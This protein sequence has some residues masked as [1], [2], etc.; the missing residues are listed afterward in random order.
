[1]TLFDRYIAVDWSAANTPRLGKDSIW[2]GEWGEDHHPGST[3]LSPSHPRENGDPRLVGRPANGD[4]RF[5][6]SDP[7]PSYAEHSA[8]QA[9]HSHSGGRG[10]LAHSLNLPTRGAAMTHLLGRLRWALERGERVFVGCDFGFGYPTGTASALTGATDWQV[11][12]ALI[13]EL[14]VD[15]E[16]NANNRFAVAERLNARLGEALFWGHPHQHRYEQLT[17]RRPTHGYSRIAE[18]RAVESLSRSAQPMFKLSGVGSVGSQSL[19]GI[20]RL[21][22]LRTEPS[23]AGQ[24]A[25]WPFETGFAGPVERPIWLVEMYPSLFPLAPDAPAPKDRAQVEAAA[26]GFA[27]LDAR[28]QLPAFLSPPPGTSDATMEVVRRE[29]GW[30]AGAGRTSLLGLEIAA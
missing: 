29:E 12:W 5:R 19:T 13:A 18:R 23:L 26:A 30:I 27:A 22:R 28:G 21:E 16:D 8:G 25:V 9:T 7:V 6:G 1:M 10:R 2:V 24:I 17:P 4:S 3:A 14:M 11:V 20:A 15:A